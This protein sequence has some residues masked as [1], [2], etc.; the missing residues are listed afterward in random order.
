MKLGWKKIMPLTVIFMLFTI[1]GMFFIK[2]YIVILSSLGLSISL[3]FF[4][5][6]ILISFFYLVSYLLV[7]CR[8]VFYFINNY[9]NKK[10]K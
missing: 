10:V 8:D 1:I 2:T 5:S 4:K 7:M 6:I 9:I 3:L